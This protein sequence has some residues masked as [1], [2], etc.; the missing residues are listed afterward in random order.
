MGFFSINY[1]KPG[2]GVDKDAPPKPRFFIFFEVL[3]RKFWHLLRVNMMFALFNIPALLIAFI[4]ASVY[5]Q[6]I[7]FDDGIG[8]FYLRFFLAAL[9]TLLPVV[10]LG[11][12]QAG[13]TYIL[14]NYSREEHSFIWWDFKETFAKNFKQGMAITAIDIVVMYILG[15]AINFYTSQSGLI[16]TAATSFVVLSLVIF[17]IMHFYIYP[18]LVTVKL[19]VKDIYKNAFIF[20]ILK[21][22]PNLLFFV[23]NVAIAYAAFYNILIGIILYLFLL[24]SFIGLM[25]NFY[26]NPIIKKYVVTEPETGEQDE[27]EEA[28]DDNDGESF[29]KKDYKEDDQE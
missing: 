14:R 5:L 2:P 3:K 17:S 15:I 25:N 9:M 27:L 24:P 19:S 21:L 8:D 29:Y 13:F 11:P 10:T 4:I 1:N 28:E 26:V 18:M 12:V 6:K 23:L 16:S 20:S 22:F 7:Q